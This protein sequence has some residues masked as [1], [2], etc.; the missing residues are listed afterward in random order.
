M[1]VCENG[2]EVSDVEWMN[3]IDEIE[4]IIEREKIGKRIEYLKDVKEEW[5]RM[6]GKSYWG[7]KEVEMNEEDMFGSIEELDDEIE[8]LENVLRLRI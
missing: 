7:E 2:K 6:I 3:M 4:R 1:Y 5:K 8:E